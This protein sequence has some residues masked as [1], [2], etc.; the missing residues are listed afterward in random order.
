MAVV[1]IVM[2][3]CLHE[4]HLQYRTTNEKRKE[5]SG[6]DLPLLLYG[7]QTLY[8]RSGEVN[9]AY[10]LNVFESKLRRRIFYLGLRN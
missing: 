5:Q 3:L 1:T 9:I 4:N 7:S 8:L 6:V 2:V 10:T